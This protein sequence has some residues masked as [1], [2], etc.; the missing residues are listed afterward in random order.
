VRGLDWQKA[1]KEVGL[2]FT[3]DPWTLRVN[4]LSI[5]QTRVHLA[6]A[7]GCHDVLGT[8]LLQECGAFVFWASMFIVMVTAPSFKRYL[9][10]DEGDKGSFVSFELS[11]PG[12][13]NSEA[14]FCIVWRKDLG[15]TLLWCGRSQGTMGNGTAALVWCLFSG[16]PCVS[17]SNHHFYPLL[18]LHC[19]ANH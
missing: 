2:G 8:S 12:L 15:S 19:P 13:W 16:R 9:P 17:F 6:L 3:S 10:C 4:L 5:C 14:T 7:P 1:L 18:R 11:K